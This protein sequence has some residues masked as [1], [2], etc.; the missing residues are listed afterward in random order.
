MS[1]DKAVFVLKHLVSYIFRK[2]LIVSLARRYP[3]FMVFGDEWWLMDLPREKVSRKS[4]TMS[5]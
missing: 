5:T 2:R 1:A 4:A 3:D